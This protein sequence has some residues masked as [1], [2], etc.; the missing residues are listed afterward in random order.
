MTPQTSAK[1][2]T[3]VSYG[4]ILIAIIWGL[5]PYQAINTPSK[6]LIDMLDW[7]LGDGPAVLDRSTRW[8]SSVGAGLLAMLSIMLL[9]IVVPAIRRGDRQPV[10]VAIWALVAWFVIDSAGSIA[11]GVASNAAFNIILLVAALIPLITVK[12]EN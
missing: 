7:P 4:F 5:A 2:L 6:L 8:L 10:R 12:L 1:T 11:A 3:F 9:G